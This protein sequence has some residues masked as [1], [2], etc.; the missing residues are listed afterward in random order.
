M[1]I[2]S[3]LGSGQDIKAAMKILSQDLVSTRAKASVQ[4]QKNSFLVYIKTRSGELIG[5]GILHLD[6]I[7]KR[8]NIEMF[9]VDIRWRGNGFASMM[10]YLIQYKMVHFPKYDLFVCAALDAV[11]FWSNPKYSFCFA[12]KN[13]LEEHEIAD[14]KTG[15]TRHL[16][17]YGSAVKARGA[18]LKCLV[19]T[20]DTKPPGK[21]GK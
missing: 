7:W 9:A 15:G 5:C 13:I 14:E 19:A 10:V 17:W 1:G 3:T 6:H 11:P 4:T 2:A 20:S 16:I 18:L 8:V 12:H 21:I